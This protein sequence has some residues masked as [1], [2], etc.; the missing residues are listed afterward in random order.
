MARTVLSRRAR[1]ELLGLD[2][3]VADAVVEAL[4]LLEREPRAGYALR[5]RLSGLRSLRTGSHRI[6]YQLAENDRLVRAV[7]I[8]HRS[9]AYRTDPR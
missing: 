4:G 5:G 3:P 7:A 8:W 6:I 9:V 2:W 1:L